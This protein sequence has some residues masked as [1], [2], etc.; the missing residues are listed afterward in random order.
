MTGDGNR[1]TAAI[2]IKDDTAEWK[3]KPVIAVHID[4]G[5]DIGAESVFTMEYLALAGALQAT[6]LLDGRL[7]ATG[8]DARSVL[9]LLSGRRQRL[10][11]VM[12]DHHYLLQCVDNSLHKGAPTPFPCPMPR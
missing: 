11:A 5:T 10:Q 6:T 1:A 2:I 7:H 3:E 8:S 9:D 12:K 4:A